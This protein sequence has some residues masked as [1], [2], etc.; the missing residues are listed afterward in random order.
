MHLYYDTTIPESYV[1]GRLNG[2]FSASLLFI[3][4]SGFTHLTETLFKYQYQGAEILSAL[5]GDVFG[6]MVK[7]VYAWHG[8]IPMFAGDGFFAVFPGTPEESARRAWQTAVTIQQY[9]VS[10]RGPFSI[11][12]TPYGNFEIGVKIG[13]SVGEVEWGIFYSDH[14]AN[15]YFRGDVLYDCTDAE[16]TAVSGEII[17]HDTILDYL[18]HGYEAWSADVP[19]F[20]KVV[21]VNGDMP[22]PEKIEP[23]SLPPVLTAY[24]RNQSNPESVSPN[25]RQICPVFVSFQAGHSDWPLLV[26]Q[27][28]RLAAQYGGRFNR[29]EFGDKGDMM[30]LWFGAPI[31]YE[32]NVERAAK[33]LLA[34]ERETAVPWRA[35][36]TYGLV[37]AGNRGGEAYSEYGCIGDALNT[38]ARIVAQTHWGQIWLDETAARELHAAYNLHAL[39]EFRFKGKQKPRSLFRLTGV[40]SH[41]DIVPI[42]GIIG[43]QNEIRYCLEAFEPIF[44]GRF[45]GMVTVQGEAGIGKSYF[46]A[47]LRQQLEERVTWLTCPADDILRESFNPFQTMLAVWCGQSSENEVSENWKLF[48]DALKQLTTRLNQVEN[49]QAPDVY[50]ELHRTQTMLA[51]LAGISLGTNQDFLDPELRFNNNILGLTAFLRAQA[52]LKPVVL[53]IEDTHWL[54]EES[55]QFLMEVPRRLA[56]FPLVLLLTGR[57]DGPLAVQPKPETA[58]FQTRIVLQ[59]FKEA[60][61]QDL[62]QQLLGKPVTDTL[63]QFL[64]VQSH[65][66]PFFIEQLIL[67]LSQ[68]GLFVQDK[69]GETAVLALDNVDHHV[70]P[71]TLNAL[72][73]VRLD[74]LSMPVKLIVQTAAVLGQRFSLSLLAAMRP[75]D[76]QLPEKVSQVVEHQIWQTPSE[77][78]VQFQHA[79]L[80][81]VAYTMQPQVQRRKLHFQAAFALEKLYADELHVYYREIAHHYYAAF[82]NG[83]LAARKSARRFLQLAGE[84]AAQMYENETAVSYFT[85]ALALSIEEVNKFALLLARESVYHLQGRRE[86]QA[87]DIEALNRIAL[88]Q[89][90]CSMVSTVALRRARFAEVLGE[91]DQGI[92]S[93]QKALSAACDQV[94]A[95]EAC[96]QWGLVLKAKG[97]YQ[98]AIPQLFEALLLAGQTSEKNLQSK[99]LINLGEIAVQHGDYQTAITHYFRALHICRNTGDRQTE[100]A[101]LNNLGLVSRMQ[102]DFETAVMHYLAAL[103]ISQE[104][105]D[106]RTE[107]RVSNNLGWIAAAG[108]QFG[109]AR[110]HFSR[111]LHISQEIG[112]VDGESQA[113]GNLGRI[114]VLLGN[115]TQAETYLAQALNAARLTGNPQGELLILWLIGWSKNVQAQWTEANT[116]FEMGQQTAQET[117]NKEMEMYCLVGQGNALAGLGQLKEGAEVLHQATRGFRELQME[118][119]ALEALTGWLRAQ[120]A[121]GNVSEIQE[122]AKELLQYL[123]AFGSFTGAEEPLLMLWSLYQ[124]LSASN[125][126][127]APEI[128]SRAYDRLKTAVSHIPDESTRKSFL[129]NVPWHQQIILAKQQVNQSLSGLT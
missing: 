21:P 119:N 80:H 96:L 22:T 124:A 17:A 7:Q 34:L 117:G 35:G 103:T 30:L 23:V 94:Q 78:Q 18:P 42:R 56:N 53:H 76:R 85:T 36:L 110:N 49:E 107:S 69:I 37:W 86:L 97:A 29:L 128:L 114:E 84:Q 50:A 116:Y 87:K 83:L 15:C 44:N 66:N 1:D 2:R 60:E 61:I 33:F 11:Y 99:A 48:I 31:S 77:G 73:T 120:L 13:M 106:R 82:E 90:A 16:Q 32:N 70:L 74:R 104:I 88:D 111:E 67:E 51:N 28:M 129:E 59:P 20:H 79:L 38:A 115:Y 10:A 98:E 27:A 8:F 46:A 71:Q 118:M 54:D 121:L 122:A 43:R 109:E 95:A 58:V 65:G 102:N 108:Y 52:L 113:L 101:V 12:V 92:E 75:G 89:E 24:L 14:Q 105:G 123:N 62:C 5:L 55:W 100:G 3:D 125:D 57:Q 126:P 9:F 93:A 26:Q 41:T 40:N 39:G 64:R 45:G 63:L 81:E 127:R 112:D 25:F 47:A 68:Q 6:E 91:Y 19:T 4:I 72:L